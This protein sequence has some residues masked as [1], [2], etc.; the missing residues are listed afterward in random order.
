MR[1][2]KITADSSANL[3]A[4]DNVSFASVP[5]KII[6][7]ENEFVDNE[8]L[9]LDEMYRFF[10]KYKGRSQTSCPNA[11]DWLESF[12]DAEDVFCI[13]ITS[14]LSGSYNTACMAK[15]MY[16]EEHPDRRVFV[17]DSLSAGPELTLLA[18]KL[19]EL[20]GKARIAPGTTIYMDYGSQELSNH[21]AQKEALMDMSQLLLKKNVNL[22]FRIIPGGDHSEASWEKQIP[23]FMDCLGL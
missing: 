17:I 3:L 15:E 23:I 8:T 7:A 11:S 4:L 1:K 9:D 6:A 12:E 2:I 18:Q 5:L 16:E 14:G 22:A 13:T 20:I 21:P 10:D 19:A